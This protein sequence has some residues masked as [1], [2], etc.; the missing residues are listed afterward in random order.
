M[1]VHEQS[2]NYAPPPGSSQSAVTGAALLMSE[3]GGLLESDDDYGI[4]RRSAE[5]RAKVSE[6]TTV[7]LHGRFTVSSRAWQVGAPPV[8]RAGYW[9]CECES[10][11]RDSQAE[12]RQ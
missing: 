11:D 6:I 9:I 4:A 2:G 8:S 10:V 3:R 1:S 5:I 7:E 12:R